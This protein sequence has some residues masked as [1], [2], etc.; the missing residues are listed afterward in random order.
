MSIDGLVLVERFVVDGI[1]SII[2]WV[3]G[4]VKFK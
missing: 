2:P 3:V 4:A 1:D